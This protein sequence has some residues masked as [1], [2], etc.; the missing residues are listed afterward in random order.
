MPDHGTAMYSFSK[1]L[2]HV[3]Y[4]LKRWNKQCFG[5]LHVQKAAAQTKLDQITRRIRDH[6]LNFELSEDESLAF[7]NLEEWEFREEI[8]WKQKSRI[9]WL[10][11]GD[12]NTAFFHNSVKA[13]RFGNTL[14]S[15]VLTDGTQISSCEGISRAAVNYFSDLFTRE[16]P[17]AGPEQQDILDCIPHLVSPE[18]NAILLSPILLPE[19]EKVV[20]NMKKGKAPGPDGFPIEFFQE[21]WEIIKYDLLD[22]VQESYSN[23][24][25]LKSLNS[26]FLVL[27]PKKEGANQLEQFRPIALC[28]VVYKII[29][30]VIAERLKPL[31]GSLI[32]TE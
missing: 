15:L 7:K 19:L 32:S 31:L 30:K 20:F 25:M 8:F 12:R 24:Q 2:Q 27:I 23:K 5:Y 18:M 10:Q 9:D 17:S 1:R 4:K 14:S 26:T 3:K 22:V 28:N 16:D 11:E 6:G 29:T 13:R 21:F